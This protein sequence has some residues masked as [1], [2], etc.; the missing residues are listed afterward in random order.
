MST[1]YFRAALAAAILALSVVPA[2]SQ[3]QSATKDPN[4]L[5]LNVCVVE[6]GELKNIGAYYN[7]TT[8]DTTLAS[9]EK[10][11]IRFHTRGYAPAK[12]WFVTNEV[13]NYAGGEYIKY[14]LP[15]EVRQIELKRAGLMDGVATFVVKSDTSSAPGV[16]YLPTTTGC[17]FQ[18]YQR[19]GRAEFYLS[20][21]TFAEGG[22]YAE[23]LKRLQR[24]SMT[25]Y[26]P[27]LI[28]LG[29]MYQ[30]G[31]GLKADTVAAKRLFQEAIDLKDP[32]AYVALGLFALERKRTDIA[33]ANFQAAHDWGSGQ[34]S[35]YLGHMYATSASYVDALQYLR[36]AANRLANDYETHLDILN[37]IAMIWERSSDERQLSRDAAAH[38][39]KDEK[40]ANEGNPISQYIT[41]RRYELGLAVPK[42]T[43]VALEFYDMSSKGKYPPGF[44]AYNRL[45]ASGQNK[46]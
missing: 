22:K 5:Y 18:P 40:T 28:L 14:G 42:D 32:E 23:A 7:K 11:G 17:I 4:I 16:V 33:R 37:Y 20:A 19:A 9:G 25:R 31:L 13:M 44:N 8:R 6:N 34:G 10:F 38:Q 29:Q 43:E 46:R 2:K 35:M 21:R 36:T 30:Q 12:S 39:A 24:P 1:S 41:G 3:A 15:R 45:K 26:T 27:A